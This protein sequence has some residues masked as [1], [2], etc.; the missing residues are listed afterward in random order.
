VTRRQAAATDHAL[1]LSLTETKLSPARTR[2]GRVVRTRLLD[3]L[4]RHAGGPLTLVTAPVGFGKTTLVQSWCARTEVAVAWMSLDAADNDP[5]RLWTY[6]AAS[7]ERVR[8]GLGRPA[9]SSLR[10]PGVAPDTVV[11]RLLSGVTAYRSELAIVFDDL[12]VL[13][14]E[15]CVRSFAHLV[16]HLPPNVHVVATTRSDPA[17]PLGRLRANG[18][19]GEIRARD[20]AFSRDEARTLLVEGEGVELDPDNVELL[21]ERT[22]GWPAGLYLASLWLRDLEDPNASVVVFHGD[23]RHVAEYLTGEVLEALDGETRR[24][25]LE[26]ST[27]GTFSGDMCDEILE[28]SDCTERLRALERENGFLVPLDPAGKWYRYHHLF[29]ELLQ[30]ELS[31]EQPERPAYLHARA[32]AWCRE[33]GLIDEALEH[34]ATARDLGRVAEI[35]ADEH[36]TLLRSGRVATVLRWCDVLPEEELLARP[37]VTLAA[38]FAAGLAAAPSHVRHRYLALAERTRSELPEIWSPYDATALALARSTWIEGDVGEAISLGRRLVTLARAVPELEVAAVATLGYACF[39]AGETDDAHRLALEAVERPDAPSRTHAFVLALST[40][41]YLESE[42]GRPD[43]GEDR[44]REALA[45]ATAT[46]VVR[47]ASGG[48]A[49]VALASALARLGRLR[50]AEREAVEGERLRRQT[51]PEAGH[52]HAL[53]VLA[54]IRARRGRVDRAAADLAEA[55]R[56][57]ETFTD[58]GRLPE[59]AAGVEKV[60][61]RARAAAGLVSEEPSVAELSVLRLLASDLSQREI[62]ARLYLSVNT[63]KTHTRSLYRKLG[64]SSREEAVERATALGLLAPDDS[65][66]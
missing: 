21:V 10:T 8:P 51:E 22:E 54:G 47:T 28:R 53:L 44:A 13:T 62:G 9:L 59:L 2:P 17:L 65:P 38:V 64:A 57:L 27:F 1:D 48:A 36:R 18:T 50:E 24:F 63:V 60:L 39:V 61:D 37:D 35:L 11:D 56:G 31:S 5:I 32:S 41:S 20:L 33:H 40:L 16:E 58:A 26:T 25:L 6:V 19:L 34:A 66:G 46:G 52:L 29:A 12:H 4:D 42:S 3:E 55:R 23:H 7:L 45:A 14:D 49:R 30:L 15:A 43:A